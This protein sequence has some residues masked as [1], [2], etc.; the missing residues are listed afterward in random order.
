MR[1]YNDEMGDWQGLNSST[2]FP[3]YAAIAELLQT[4]PDGG[5][6]LDV[7]C[8]EA[9][10]R[11]WLPRTNYTGIEPSALA[12]RIARESNPSSKFIHTSAENFDSCGACFDTIVFNEMLYYADD[13]VGLL[14]KYAGLIR[15][16][17]MILCSVYQKPCG[18]LLKR[19]LRHWLDPRQSISNIHCE[20][21]VRDFM[22]QEAWRILDD[23]VV[24]IP[25]GGEWHIWLATPHQSF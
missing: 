9:L 10:L 8:G 16:G 18:V 6:V 25:E 22:V 7:G 11:P 19:R 5:S 2:Q 17:G 15:Q 20:K 4:L 21:M 1:P 14:R 23:R 13:P 24:L 3:R 12:V